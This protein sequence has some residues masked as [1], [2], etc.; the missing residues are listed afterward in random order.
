MQSEDEDIILDSD[1]FVD[2]LASLLKSA[3]IENTKLP[4]L[5]NEIHQVLRSIFESIPSTESMLLYYLTL[6]TI[7]SPE[8]L[9]KILDPETYIYVKKINALH[10]FH[11]MLNTFDFKPSAFQQFSNDPVNYLLNATRIH[12]RI[13]NLKDVLNNTE[14]LPTELQENLSEDLKSYIRQSE[15]LPAGLSP[16]HTLNENLKRYAQPFKFL[17]KLI[18]RLVIGPLLLTLSAGTATKSFLTFILKDYVFDYIILDT[19]TG[20]LFSERQNTAMGKK[21]NMAKRKYLDS[22]RMKDKRFAELADPELVRLLAELSKR[23]KSY[24]GDHYE[25]EIIDSAVAVIIKPTGM[26][27]LVIAASAIY[28]KLFVAPWHQQ[29]IYKAVGIIAWPL[30]LIA[31]VPVLIATAA[32]EGINRLS[33]YSL[34]V[35][36]VIATS[37]AALALV[38]VNLPLLVW[39]APSYLYNKIKNATSRS[40]SIEVDNGAAPS[41]VSSP[42]SSYHHLML[43]GLVSTRDNESKASDEDGMIPAAYRQQR[44]PHANLSL[45]SSKPP[46]VDPQPASEKPDPYAGFR[47]DLI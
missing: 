10:T 29:N 1:D 32:V 44:S 41:V 13:E 25:T 33:D 16:L 7:T 12:T 28:E 43:R 47:S 4:V 15:S 21:A 9:K 42:K 23:S 37:I 35:S 27:Y 34:V 2:S 17:S 31:A 22:F 24:E 6:E 39:D 19:L 18:S 26:E 8:N 36:S 5:E 40:A 3:R 46:V 30:R 20:D 45:L 38:T 11:K 14:G